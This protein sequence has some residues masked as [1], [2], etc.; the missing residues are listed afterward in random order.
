RA[1]FHDAEEL[2]R[3]LRTERPRHWERLAVYRRD[4][5]A[6]RP[7]P[8]PAS[9]VTI[10]SLEPQPRGPRKSPTTRGERSSGKK[11]RTRSPGLHPASGRRS[12][13]YLRS[14]RRWDL[15]RPPAFSNET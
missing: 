3:W 5:T 2:E 13:S 11:P 10:A 14:T 15:E 6:E 8:P 9:L 7:G 12:G 4:G 1:W